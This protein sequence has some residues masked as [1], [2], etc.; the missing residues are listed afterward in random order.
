MLPSIFKDWIV[1]WD[2]RDNNRQ[3]FIY[4]RFLDSDDDGVIDEKDIFPDDHTEWN[5]TD[6]D[7]IGDNSDYYPD[8]PDRWEKEKEKDYLQILIPI[9]ILS[10]ILVGIIIYSISRKRKKIHREE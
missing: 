9:G 10:I 5:D 1:W 6:S 8:D 7:G 2:L 4:S 3:V